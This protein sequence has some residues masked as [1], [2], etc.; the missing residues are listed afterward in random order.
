MIK[1]WK[2]LVAGGA[3]L[4][5]GALGFGGCFGHGG[6]NCGPWVTGSI[7]QVCQVDN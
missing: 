4:L 1:S 3:V 7:Q 5:M 6:D 2:R